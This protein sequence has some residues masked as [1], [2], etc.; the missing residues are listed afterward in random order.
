[1]QNC[2][3]LFAISLLNDL[4]KVM[5]GSTAV[6]FAMTLLLH[7]RRSWV[8]SSPGILRSIMFKYVPVWFCYGTYTFSSSVK[9]PTNLVGE[10][11]GE[12]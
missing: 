10:D 4:F 11:F 1:M 2:K 8:L 5:L 6:V 9:I 7:R 12:I 3:N